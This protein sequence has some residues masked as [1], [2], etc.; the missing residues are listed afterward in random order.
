LRQG[1]PR[2]S[3]AKVFLFR[4]HGKVPELSH[5]HDIP[6][7]IENISISLN[8]ILDAIGSL[9]KYRTARRRP[10]GRDHA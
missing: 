8:Y 10:G 6:T 5:V 3:T 2:R 7:Y 4:E 1:K 9:S